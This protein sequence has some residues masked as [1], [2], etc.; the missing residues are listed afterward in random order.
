M[1][2]T[3]WPKHSDG[4]NKKM[5]EMTREESKLA[6]AGPLAQLKKELESPQFLAA[7]KKAESAL[8]RVSA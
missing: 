5:G 3:N 6:L 2:D 1:N 4:R 8:P 7:L